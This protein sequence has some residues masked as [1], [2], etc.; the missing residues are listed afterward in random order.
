MCPHSTST[1]VGQ[2]MTSAFLRLISPLLW[3]TGIVSMT[4]FSGC[5]AGLG[6]Q[7]RLSTEAALYCGWN[8]DGVLR[9]ETSVAANERT[10]AANER[11]D[12]ADVDDSGGRVSGGDL[13]PRQI[14]ERWALPTE[15]G[16]SVWAEVDPAQDD[17]LRFDGAFTVAALVHFDERP[18]GR[19][20]ILSR[21]VT[22][23][24]GRAFELGMEWDGYPYFMVSP[25]GRAAGHGIVY[26]DV[27]LARRGTVLLSAS[28]EPRQRLA[29]YAN[30]ILIGDNRAVVPGAMHIPPHP[31]RIGSRAGCGTFCTFDGAIGDVMFFDRALDDADHGALAAEFGMDEAAT[32]SWEDPA[33]IVYD[34]DALAD[35][36]REW[37]DRLDTGRWPGAYKWRESHTE[38][39][40]YAS[41]DVAWIR[42]M[43]GDL[44]ELDDESRRGW[45]AFLQS[46]QDPAD[47]SYPPQRLHDRAHALAHVTV[48]LN[49]LD[50]RHRHPIRFV[51]PLQRPGAVEPWLESLD[52]YWQW[53][54]SCTLWGIGMTL[55]SSYSTPV[56]WEE[57]LFAWLDREVDPELGAWRRDHP[58]RH[59]VDWIGGGFHI[60]TLYASQG[61]PLPHVERIIDLALSLQRPDGDFDRKFGCGVL[62]GV[63]ALA[64][65]GEQTDYRRADVEAALRRSL[66]GLMDLVGR[67]LFET[68]SHGMLSRIAT[69]AILQ[70]A[71]PTDFTSERP[72][73]SPWNEAALF[74]LLVER[75][76]EIEAR[77][78]CPPS[79]ER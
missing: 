62:D 52:W 18:Q 21:W 60:W 15:A 38:P 63:W 68:G 57:D 3:L 77:E 1:Q 24:L 54:G 41:A 50:G 76:N 26:A 53:G 64:V 28:F 56:E 65:A 59:P 67:D 79:S 31:L 40:L 29:M 30:G 71:L 20:A 47:G 49:V 14:G 11:T 34:L 74:E 16:R 19:A 44:D 9:C 35:S 42:W 43:I 23:G 13:T 2:V 75:D 32:L 33:F 6:E 51:E 73:R 45:I 78:P 27:P 58:V 12:A 5:E 37:Y 36:V 25:S 70:R 8:V 69:I 55:L 4:C 66:Q 61:R 72:W 46:H 22:S 17:L 7:P 48:A 39:H 10:D